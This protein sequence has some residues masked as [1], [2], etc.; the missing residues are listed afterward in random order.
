[1]TDTL[2]EPRASDQEDRHF[3]PVCSQLIDQPLRRVGTGRRAR[4]PHCGCLE[5]HRFLAILLSSIEP[6]LPAAP[7]V[8]EVAPSPYTTPLLRRLAVGGG[9]RNAIDGI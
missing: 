7:R 5:R 8:L 2:V 6:M 3:C 1:M 9:R 4:C